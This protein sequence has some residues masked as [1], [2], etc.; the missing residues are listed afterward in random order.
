MAIA[1]TAFTPASATGDF[2]KT[3]PKSERPDEPGALEQR[4]WRRVSVST[5]K[6]RG[7]GDMM[8]KTQQIELGRWAPA[9]WPITFNNPRLSNGGHLAAREQPRRF[10]EEIRASF[11]P[12]RKSVDG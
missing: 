2:E 9:Y 7:L 3:W 5:G 4:P 11:R 10:S 1:G 8:T 6:D 12:L